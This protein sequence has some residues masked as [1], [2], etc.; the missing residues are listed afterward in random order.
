MDT[1]VDGHNSRIVDF[2]SDSN[3][4]QGVEGE[5]RELGSAATI[6]M[7]GNGR[8]KA[9]V[10]QL[11]PKKRDGG[12]KASFGTESGGDGIARASRARER[13]PAEAASQGA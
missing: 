7:L 10:N 11:L 9:S 12:T 3:A 1:I 2:E 13:R 6:E 4:R 5:E 8:G